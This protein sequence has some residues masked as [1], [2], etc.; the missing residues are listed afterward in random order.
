MHF[1]GYRNIIGQI[2]S[3]TEPLIEERKKVLSKLRRDYRIEN[4]SHVLK[5]SQFQKALDRCNCN[6]Y[7]RPHH[8]CFARSIFCTS[9]RNAV[10][11]NW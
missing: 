10:R 3:V 11:R 5:Y 1:V 4:N 7:D 9:L 8:R 2:Q 6:T